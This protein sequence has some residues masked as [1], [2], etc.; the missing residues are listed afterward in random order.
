MTLDG[1]PEEPE[2]EVE[3]DEE[4]EEAAEPEVDDDDVAVEDEDEEQPEEEP[5]PEADDDPLPDDPVELKRIAR[6]RRAQATEAARLAERFERI[7]VGVEK[8]QTPPP[9][10]PRRPADDDEDEFAPHLNAAYQA[11]VS[12]EEPDLKT[13][14]QTVLALTGMVVKTRQLRAR[15]RMERERQDLDNKAEA[16]IPAKHKAAVD[17]ISEQFGIPK[18]VAW[19]LKKGELYDAARAKSAGKKAAPQKTTT[20]PPVS[21]RGESKSTA[22]RPVRTARPGEG[23]SVVTLS[24]GLKVRTEHTPES[25][26]RLMDQLEAQGKTADRRE[27]LRLRSGPDARIKLKV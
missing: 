4:P 24:S 11:L 27:I 18:I 15:D 8:P 19:Q 9:A 22:M 13:L 1:D 7:A 25:Y 3:L 6:E 20:P 2:V 26:A 21:P 17:A 5:E 10:A 14:K 12:Q 23:G 16:S